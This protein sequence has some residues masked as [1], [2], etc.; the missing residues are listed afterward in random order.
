MRKVF[1]LENLGGLVSNVL[2]DFLSVLAM[3][4]DHLF[5]LRIGSLGNEVPY[6][7]KHGSLS[8][9]TLKSQ[10]P[11]TLYIY[12]WCKDKGRILIYLYR[13]WKCMFMRHILLKDAW[14][15]MYI[16]VRAYIFP[17]EIKYR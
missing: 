4:R 11:L 8:N 12:F 17:V 16:H 1:E 6:A 14:V 13:N 9:S 7:L 3:C 10:S 5:A 2:G 15:D